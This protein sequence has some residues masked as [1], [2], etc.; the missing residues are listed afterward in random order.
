M[1]ANGGGVG[2]AACVS[3]GRDTI[4]DGAGSSLDDGGSEMG[5]GRSTG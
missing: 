4:Y 1:L 3:K 5:L 2:E